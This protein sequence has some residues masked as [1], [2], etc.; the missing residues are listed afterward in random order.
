[1]AHAQPGV[2]RTP[3]RWVGWV[4]FASFTMITLGAIEVMMAMVAFFNKAYYSVA[5]SALA[6]HINYTGWGIIQLGFGLLLI[7]AGYGLLAGQTWARAVAIVVAFLSAVANLAFIAANP[8]WALT[9]IT[10]D[11][12]VIYAVSVHGAESRL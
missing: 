12:I 9:V 2:T 4:V 8:W 11:V 10:L 5:S 3:T 6:L 7:A 1:M